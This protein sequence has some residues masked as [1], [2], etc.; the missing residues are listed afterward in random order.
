MFMYMY[1][2]IIKIVRFHTCVCTVH[3][4]TKLTNNLLPITFET[5]INLYWLYT[6]M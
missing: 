4:L 6:C 2:Y 3:V 5:L 1:M